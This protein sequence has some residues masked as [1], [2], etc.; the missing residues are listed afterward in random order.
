MIVRWIDCS[1]GAM[2]ALLSRALVVAVGVASL[3]SGAWAGSSERL[4]T[5]GATELL[6]PVGARGTALGGGYA[7]EVAGAEAMFW[8]PAGLAS[9]ESPEALFTH[10]Q[11]FADMKLNY[12]ALAVKAKNLGVVGFSAK[13]LSIGD[14]FVTTEESPE[15]TG[16]V[17]NPTYSVLGVSWAKEFTDR[18]HFGVTMDLVN[19][20]ILQMNA[21][22]VAF[23][24]G[25]QYA[26][27][28]PG[29]K[30][31]M[32]MKNFG[33][34]MQFSG[35]NLDVSV[36]PPGAEPGSSNRIVSFSSAKF[37]MPSFFALSASYEA[38]HQSQQSLR[39]LGAFQNNNFQGDHFTG[40]AEWT[41]RDSYALRGS[42]FGTFESTTDPVTG[43]QTSEFTRG[44]ELYSGLALGGGASFK[45]GDAR[46]GV[47][48][49]WRP[50]RE[51]FD[52]VVEVGLK[53]QF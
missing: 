3:A 49:A 42:W 18:V 25:V 12:V 50:V 8:N 45:A 13:V 7:A 27:E 20:H 40:S 1:V 41:Y 39:L 36:L 47:D 2:K 38:W 34:S 9:V 16:E 22:G 14:V 33:T 37:E 53:V 15:G 30:L 19:E 17:F 29:L 35:D 52:D 6:I 21:N 44:D 11:Y 48:V 26:T 28:L 4:G 31:A 43:E 10:T 51:F 5:G 46:L 32:T 23:D 24:F